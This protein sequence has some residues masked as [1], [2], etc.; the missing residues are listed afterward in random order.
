MSNIDTLKAAGLIAKEAQF[1]QADQDIIESLSQEEVKA[2]ISVSR[3]LTPEFVSRNIAG[4]SEA[5]GRAPTVR[6]IGIVF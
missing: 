2:L 3:K 6:T 4:P 5:G 1:N